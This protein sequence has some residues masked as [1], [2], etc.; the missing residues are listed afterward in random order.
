MEDL[1]EA[2]DKDE[3]QKTDTQAKA[4][5]AKEGTKKDKNIVDNQEQSDDLQ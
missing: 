5:E 2:P 4:A 3:V 1:E